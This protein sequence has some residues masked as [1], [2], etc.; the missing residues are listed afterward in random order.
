MEIDRESGG[1]LA[2]TKSVLLHS[3]F[4][5][6]R[7]GMCDNGAREL[8]MI[9]IEDED[10]S[11]H[12]YGSLA[13]GD[14]VCRIGENALG[15]PTTVC[16]EISLP[17]LDPLEDEEVDDNSTSRLLRESEPLALSALRQNLPGHKIND[18][19]RLFDDSG[20]VI[21]VMVVWTSEAE[22]L[23]SSLPVGCTLTSTTEMNMQGLVEL[24]IEETNE[25]FEVSGVLTEL[26]LVHAYRHPDYVEPSSNQFF[27]GLDDITGTADGKMDDVHAL[28][29]L[30]GA[31]VVALILGTGGFCGV[32]H[33]GPN[34]GKMFSATKY[35][36]ATGHFS[37]GRFHLYC[38]LSVVE[39]SSHCL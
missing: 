2:C 38:I 12:T 1:M 30:Y 32:A 11:L 9:Q 25:A 17:E 6:F 5:N 37:F 4:S 16:E 7:Q 15:E 8:N 18:T 31:D 13:I 19:R 28:R 20:A 3:H 35:S 39:M 24:A 29:E 36:C 33:L 21:D 14:E 22:C 34:K 27:D 26:R 23:Q 10:G